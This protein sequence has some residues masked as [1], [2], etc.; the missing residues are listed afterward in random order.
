MMY[1]MKNL[2]SPSEQGERTDNAFSL[3]PLAITSK[4]R[5]GHIPTVTSEGLWDEHMV[6]S[7]SDPCVPRISSPPSHTPLGPRESVVERNATSD[8]AVCPL[9]TGTAWVLFRSQDRPWGP[10]AFEA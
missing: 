3:Q 8:P 4:C 9:G 5:D 6:S 10:L 2:F 1:E 7:R